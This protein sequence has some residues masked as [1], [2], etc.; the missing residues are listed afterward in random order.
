MIAAPVAPDHQVLQP[1][2][3]LETGDRIGYEV[4]SRFTDHS[5]AEAF[6]AAQQT[7]TIVAL[8]LACI[9]AAIKTFPLI[10]PGTF[11]DVNV[12][13][14]TMVEAD[15]LHLLLDNGVPPHRL[16]L[17]VTEDAALDYLKVYEPTWRL[18]QRGVRL[19]LDDMGKSQS[20]SAYG[21]IIQLLPNVMKIDRSLVQGIEHNPIQRALVRSMVGMGSD[22]AA[23]VVAEGV[24]TQSEIDW[25]KTIGVQFGQG[26][27][28]CR[29]MRLE[30]L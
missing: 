22:L 16:V 5:P 23:M 29:P 25:L 18:R 9:T 3:D 4:L 10:P 21:R 13:P 12:D 15:L 8:D 1:I 27:G 17:E 24:E 26:F 28:L 7:G 14:A 19:A 20:D 2:S 30:E 11:L 6:A